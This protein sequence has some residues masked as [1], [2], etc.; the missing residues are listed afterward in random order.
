MWYKFLSS[1]NV[2]FTTISRL[3]FQQI[4]KR[5]RN[6]W[7]NHYYFDVV[8]FFKKQ[9]N[10]G[11][12]KKDKKWIRIEITASKWW[13]KFHFFDRTIHTMFFFR[14]LFICVYLCI[15]CE[16]RF[17]HNDCLVWRLCMNL[18]VCA[19]V[20]GFFLYVVLLPKVLELRDS[21]KPSNVELL[22]ETLS[23]CPCMY[24][25][26]MNFWGALNVCVRDVYKTYVYQTLTNQYKYTRRPHSFL[27]SY[28]YACAHRQPHTHSHTYT[29]MRS[30]FQSRL[31]VKRRMCKIRMC[32]MT[33]F[34][35]L[36]L[37]SALL[38]SLFLVFSR[39]FFFAPI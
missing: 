12:R 18:S 30:Q 29:Y 22:K 21:Q 8:F 32:T 3:S 35:L 28:V 17:N 38:Y 23:C 33:F 39:S 31:Y 36:L 2:W 37:I 5:E 16:N 7:T 4:S 14:S 25:C 11:G 15:W 27:H 26:S 19:C 13:S 6:F 34:F 1:K 9:E 24:A 10:D 20:C